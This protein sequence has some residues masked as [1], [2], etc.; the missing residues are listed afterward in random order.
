MFQTVLGSFWPQ[1]PRWRPTAILDIELFLTF[2]PGKLDA[3]VI[4]QFWLISVQEI[5]LWMF[6][7]ALGRLDPEIQDGGHLGI[8]IF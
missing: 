8:E 2:E 5:H 6:Q 3:N 4:A 1:N 7:T